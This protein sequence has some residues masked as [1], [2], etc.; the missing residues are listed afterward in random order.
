[1]EELR[2]DLRRLRG[3]SDPSGEEDEASSDGAGAA[4]APALPQ[5]RAAGGPAL[6]GGVAPWT[7]AE[8]S[9]SNVTTP[10]RQASA[11]LPGAASKGSAQASGG[12]A[13]QNPLQPLAST[14]GDVGSVA[15]PPPLAS[16]ADAIAALSQLADLAGRFESED[17]MHHTLKRLEVVMGPGE[18]GGKEDMEAKAVGWEAEEMG[19]ALVG[20]DAEEGEEEDGAQPAKAED[21]HSQQRE[22]RRD[23]PPGDEEERGGGGGGSSDTRRGALPRAGVAATGGNGGQSGDRQ[24]G[25]GQKGHT[26]E[27]RQASAPFG[28][29]P[30]GEAP[31]D[32]SGGCARLAGQ[33]PSI[34]GAASK[35]SGASASG[36]HAAG[37]PAA[38]AGEESEG[39]ESD[40]ES[41][42]G[43]D[44]SA[45]LSS[46]GLTDVA[47]SSPSPALQGSSG[48]PAVPVPRL[49][50]AALSAL[51]A[52][53]DRVDAE[54]T[55]AAVAANAGL[56]PD[57]SDGEAGDGHVHMLAP[58]VAANAFSSQSAT[59]T[60]HPPVQGASV[61]LPFALPG[62]VADEEGYQQG[63]S[64]V[65]SA[66]AGQQQPHT[67]TSPGTGGAS[68]GS[69]LA[70]PTGA[71]LHG[72]SGN[73]SSG[74]GGSDEAKAAAVAAMPVLA[75]DDDDVAF[76]TVE[77]ARPDQGEACA[78][79]E[80]NEAEG[81]VLG[82][83]FY[84]CM[85]AT[86]PGKGPWHIAGALPAGR[87]PVV[88]QEEDEKAG[89]PS[90]I[91]SLCKV[92][93]Y[94]A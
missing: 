94:D 15:R 53:R 92:L 72:S 55:A 71:W 75:G 64:S 18:D 74:R 88:V 19:K 4:A 49:N 52:E 89:S 91:E 58:V 50:L 17:D 45:S 54:A 3:R 39:K 80:D 28:G 63:D 31:S 51:V 6:A 67:P 8:A 57:G 42:D 14:P 78:E 84:T 36:A 2:A 10:E 70:S 85:P 13:A 66:A 46:A 27:Q 35:A 83:A 12:V 23:G 68:A 16:G 22:Q 40:A 79:A 20:D 5:R 32:A 43:F 11:G 30:G 86:G 61:G 69:H 93:E 77:R 47:P 37:G 44:D 81:D 29:A 34:G 59:S 87:A 38:S 62:L 24:G 73:G 21:D 26:G 60:S 48:R 90:A 65:V 33:R 41:G 7:A 25:H 1:M 76:H 82:Q 56:G 9:G